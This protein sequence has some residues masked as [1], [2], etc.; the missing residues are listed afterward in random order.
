MSRAN[1]SMTIRR[2]G[3]AD[4]GSLSQLAALDGAPVPEEPVLLAESEGRMLAAVPFLGGRALADPF[5][6]T[7]EIVALLE[8]RARQIRD[9]ELGGRKRPGL[10]RRL[11]ARLA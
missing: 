3:V 10:L 6:P 4:L 11:R 5:E 8:L 1:T 2:A 7:A 9:A